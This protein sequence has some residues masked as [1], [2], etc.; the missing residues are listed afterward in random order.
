MLKHIFLLLLFYCISC[1]PKIA[2]NQNPAPVEV[3]VAPDPSPVVM[4]PIPVDPSVRIG[5]LPNGITYYIKKNAKP[6]N[7]AELRMAI[8]AGSIEEDPDQLGIAHLVE[9]MAF[10]GSRNFSKNELVNYLESV[11]SRFGP[12]LNAYTSFDE[13]V[14]ML[15]VRSDDAEHL[16]KGMLILRD[17]ADGVSFEDEE[18]DKE[19]GVVIS[20][21]RSRLSPEQRMQQQYLPMIYYKS[22]YAE[23]LPIGD[24]E[25]LKTVPYD[26]VRRFYK[27]WYRPDM[28]AILVVGDINV[29]TIEA[30]IK[31]QFGGIVQTVDREKVKVEFPPHDETFARVITDHEASNARIRI[32]YKHKH[33][34]VKDLLTYRQSL[35]HSLYN[36]MLS[37]RL[38]EI[39]RQS[40]PPFVFGYSGY[41]QDVG[42]MGTYTSTAMADAK[43]IRRAYK[44]LLEENQRVLLHGF[45]DTELLREKAAM[46]RMAEQNVL[47][48]DKQESARI[49]SR[50]VYHFLEDSPIPDATQTLEMYKSMLPTISTSE[51]SKLAKQWITDRNRIVFI[52]APEKDLPMLPDSVEL[53][54]L[55]NEISNQQL[56]AYEDIDISAP[57]LSGSFPVKPVI[58]LTHDKD[59][60]IYHWQFE[61][62]VRVSAKPTDFKNDE[63]LM[64]AYSPGGHSVYDLS[65]YPSARSAS[66]VVGSSGVGTFNATALDKK[67]TGLRVY[68]SPFIF[69]RYEGFNGSAAVSDLETMMQLIYSYATAFREDTV[70]LNAFLSREKTMFANLLSNPDNWYS[71][72]VTKIS[73]QYHP[74]R[75]YPTLESYNRVKMEEIMNIYRDRFK[76][77][78]DMQFFF[79]GSFDPD[80]LQKLTS[81]Y[82]GALP[83]SGR[84]ESWKDVGDRMPSGVVDSVFTRGEA[85]R[86]QVQIIYHGNDHY[87]LDTAYVLQSLIDLARIKLRESLREEESGVYGVGIYGGQTLYPIE[88][89]SIRVMFNADPPRT[90]ELIDA[91]KMVIQK[92]KEDIDSADIAKVTEIQRQGR[93][94]DIKQNQFWMNGLITSWINNT[95]LKQLV[96]IQALENRINKLN[97]EVLLK[98]ARKYFNEGE[99]ISVV[100]YPE[101]T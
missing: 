81:R 17:W 50:L 101:K 65:L 94:R 97:E 43:N 60:D 53:V 78:S 42:E 26:V 45:T 22:R 63:I 13:T 90:K 55:M 46:M 36:R 11:G 69:E 8:K 79:V 30:K 27:D 39:S 68:V 51:I 5:K 23:R 38:T 10:N 44:T 25:L 47:E 87:D 18:I 77:L 70:A 1:S 95:D 29:D 16:G 93:I 85:P 61:N 89:Y 35:V 83:G 57:L 31:E 12:D 82:L 86:S 84:K 41:N 9:H 20:E 100:M 62:G 80:S 33:T 48:Q 21:W 58:N 15:Q 7:R 19:R 76:D 6:E 88:Q 73:T 56:P 99:L 37:K 59:L 24:P 54:T 2:Q 4:S 3:H 32:I 96:E 64:N 75:G 91:A 34:P 49:V 67:L 92:L 98:A 74:R 66:G 40:D 14:Y 52:T 72:K 28:T 71:D